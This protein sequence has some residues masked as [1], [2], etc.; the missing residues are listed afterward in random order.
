MCVCACVPCVCAC[1]TCIRVYIHTYIHTC[2]HT[3]I[4]TYILHTCMHAC[5]HTYIHTYVRTYTHTCIHTYMHACIH[6]CIHTY[7]HTYVRTYVHTYIHTYI[8]VE[9]RGVSVFERTVFIEYKFDAGAATHYRHHPSLEQ[10]AGLVHVP[11][12]SVRPWVSP[13]YVYLRAQ[14]CLPPLLPPSRSL[15]SC[16]YVPV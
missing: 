4:H 2:M 5:M 15:I 7:I 11:S 10:G 6:T 16:K 14:A 3:Y 1:V 12:W 9:L 13:C 8:H